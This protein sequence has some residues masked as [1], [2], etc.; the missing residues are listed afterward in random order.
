MARTVATLPAGARIT[1]YI[2]L[3]V[4]TKTFPLTAVHSVLA[5]SGKASLRERDLPAHVV[6]YYVIALALFMQ[7]SYREVLRCLLEGL[8]WLRDP[9]VPLK[10]AGKSG[11][12]QAR[13]RLG[14]EAV[15]QLHDAVVRPI[16]LPAT[17][18]AWYRQWRLV[19]QPAPAKAGGSTLDIADEAANAAAFGRPGSG[20]GSS[21]YPQIRFVSLVENGTH[22]LFGS[23]M[24]GCTT[25]E[26]PLAQEVLAG[27]QPGMLCLADRQFFG[28]ELWRQACGTGAALL[29][30]I[31]KNIRLPCAKRLSDGS[32]LSHLYACEGDRRHKTSGVPVRVIEYRLDGV[33]GA[34]PLY[35]LVTT[36][37][38]PDQAPARE[39][40]ALYHERWEIETALDELKTHLRGARIVLRSKTPDLVRQEFYGL[41]LAHFAIRGLMHEAALQA[42]EDPDRLSFVHAVHVVRRK[43]ATFG[44]LSPS[45]E[46]NIS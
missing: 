9:A 3:G 5:A 32:Y 26:I 8:Q 37:R 43:L 2:S 7:A 21:A 45:E 1:D 34:E 16:A 6:M 31:K 13:T 39:V 40:A 25:G 42:D 29:W 38:D 44:A 36:I 15:R 30:R 41:I 11:I 27:L 4:I 35:R 24:A 46:G 10:V 33:A 12:S 14:W 17:R 20:R 19:S 23:H 22:V 28:F 18:G